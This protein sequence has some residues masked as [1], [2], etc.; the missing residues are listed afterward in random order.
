MISPTSW[1]QMSRKPFEDVAEPL[2]TVARLAGARHLV[3]LAGEAHEA[4]F[5]PELLQRDEELLG[6]LDGAAQVVLGVEDP[7]RGHDILGVR[8]G[9]ALDV[10]RHVLPRKRSSELHHVE[11]MSDVARTEHRVLTVDRALRA[12]G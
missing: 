12:R 4:H 5:A 6:L 11:A 9:R 8:E 7:E 10:A 3:V 2:E 1:R